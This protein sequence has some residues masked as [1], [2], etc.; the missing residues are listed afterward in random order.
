MFVCICILATHV[1]AYQSDVR[2]KLLKPFSHS[3]NNWTQKNNV[4]FFM[5][6]I[7]SKVSLNKLREKIWIEQIYHNPPNTIKKISN[8]LFNNKFTLYYNS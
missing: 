6:H 7:T 4:W 8:D 5:Y 2:F 3:T 1:N